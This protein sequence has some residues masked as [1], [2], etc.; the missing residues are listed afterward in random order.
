[1]YGSTWTIPPHQKSLPRATEVVPRKWRIS[2][3]SGLRRIE[4]NLIAI[5]VRSLGYRS[6]VKDKPQFVPIVVNGYELESVTSAKLLG[7]IISSNLTWNEHLEISDVIK[8]ASNRLYF[9]VPLKRS[10][11][12]WQDMSTL[13]TACIRS[14]RWK[15]L[16]FGQNAWLFEILTG[17]IT[18]RT[19]I[20]TV[21][22]LW[23]WQFKFCNR[24]KGWEYLTT[25][26]MEVVENWNELN[27][28]HVTSF[29]VEHSLQLDI[30]SKY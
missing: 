10:R 19:L 8:K 23:I 22:E 26:G 30:S 29:H 25:A 14:R 2:L 15:L 7:L 18:G 13:Y 28:S 17:V 24:P 20:F 11:V 12:P 1:M 21:P 9:L 5:S 6:F 16:E 3:R 27:G 4:S